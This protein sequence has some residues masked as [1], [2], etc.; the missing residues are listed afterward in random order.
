MEVVAWY[1][2]LWAIRIVAVFLFAAM[3][4]GWA[5]SILYWCGRFRWVAGDSPR[6]GGY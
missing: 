5:V 1:M 6:R 4:W 2:A 3:A